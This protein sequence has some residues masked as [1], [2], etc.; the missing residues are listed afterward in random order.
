M[1]L[2]TAF[3]LFNLPKKHHSFPQNPLFIPPELF[4]DTPNKKAFSV[5]TMFPEQCARTYASSKWQNLWLIVH[6][7]FVKALNFG[8][9]FSSVVP[10]IF[11]NSRQDFSPFSSF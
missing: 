7:R 9:S 5:T 6:E 8:N 11:R 1:R 3:L 4:L 2:S 10:P